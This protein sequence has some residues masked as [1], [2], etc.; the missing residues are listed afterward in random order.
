[1]V[2]QNKLKNN[3]IDFVKQNFK[4]TAKR[5]MVYNNV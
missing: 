2:K 1:M 5:T 3:G 4:N